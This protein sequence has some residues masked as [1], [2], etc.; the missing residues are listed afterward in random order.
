MKFKFVR[1]H[2]LLILY[3]CIIYKMLASRFCAT[4]L[5]MPYSQIGVFKSQDA[6]FNYFMQNFNS[7]MLIALYVVVSYTR[8]GHTAFLGLLG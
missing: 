8:Y 6:T 1:I 4:N 7:N 2:I 5:K 3:Q